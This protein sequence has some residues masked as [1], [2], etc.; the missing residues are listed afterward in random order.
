MNHYF[1]N[2][3]RIKLSDLRRFL[4]F[5]SSRRACRFWEKY[6]DDVRFAEVYIVERVL[7]GRDGGFFVKDHLMKIIDDD[8]LHLS[9]SWDT[10]G[11]DWFARSLFEEFGDHAR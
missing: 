9:F 2:E 3:E 6:S 7:L 10:L 4:Q 5:R 11:F 1:P 8:V